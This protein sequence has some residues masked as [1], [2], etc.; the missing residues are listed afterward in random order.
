MIENN[1]EGWALVTVGEFSDMASYLTDV[2]LD[3]L[4]RFIHSFKTGLLVCIPFDSER[5]EHMIVSDFLK[6]YII[7]CS[8]ELCDMKII[9]N[10]DL[11]KTELAKE[12]T[13]DID[14]NYLSWVDFMMDEPGDDMELEDMLKSRLA[15][16]KK[17]LS[18]TLGEL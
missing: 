5:W 15:E 11:G 8:P 17:L 18:D 7:S 3:C 6:T 1:D 16:L 14:D 13:T 12:L 9:Y 2:P 10:T 4:N